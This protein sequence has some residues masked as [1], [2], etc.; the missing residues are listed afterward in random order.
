MHQLTT[1]L[2]DMQVDPR[3]LSEDW[4]MLFDIET[5]LKCPVCRVAIDERSIKTIDFGSRIE[6]WTYDQLAQVLI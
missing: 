4:M 6:T 5:N 3:E 2:D 1:L